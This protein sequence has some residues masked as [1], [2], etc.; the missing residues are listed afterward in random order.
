MS[1]Q[2]LRKFW[3][4]LG[5][6]A[7]QVPLVIGGHE[8]M[9]NREDWKQVMTCALMQEDRIA[10][11]LDGQRVVLGLRLRDIF[12]GLSEADARQRASDLLMLVQAFGDSH[13]VVWSDPKEQ[14]LLA[15]YEAEA[16]R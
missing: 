7:R 11:G 2:A 14:A 3:A 6:I 13:G 9:A 12:A 10:D 5:D 15:Q 8:V 16:R 1:P 4:M